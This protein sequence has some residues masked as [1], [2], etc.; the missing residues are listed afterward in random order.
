MK[1]RHLL[2]RLPNIPAVR[3]KQ[4]QEQDVG[5]CIAAGDHLVPLLGIS[6]DGQLEKVMEQEVIR[7]LRVLSPILVQERSGQAQNGVA[8]AGRDHP[9]GDPLA[10]AVPSGFEILEDKQVT[11]HHI[12]RDL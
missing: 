2:H 1:G 7:H 6:L 10:V 8:R 9:A 12:R 11:V 5:R 4:A 3:L